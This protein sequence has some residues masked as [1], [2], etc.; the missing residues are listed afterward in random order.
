MWDD[1][2]MLKCGEQEILKRQKE[3]EL[4]TRQELCGEEHASKGCEMYPRGPGL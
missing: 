2:N 1:W 4:E 3:G